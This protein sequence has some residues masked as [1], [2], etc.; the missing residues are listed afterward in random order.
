MGCLTSFMISAGSNISRLRYQGVSTCGRTSGGSASHP[1][2]AARGLED[3]LLKLDFGGPIGL[4][5]LGEVE[6]VLLLFENRFLPARAGAG[7]QN[8]CGNPLF[9]RRQHRN[10]RTFGVTDHEHALVVDVL[11]LGDP[12][13]HRDGVFGVVAKRHGFDAAAALP[14]AALVESQHDVAEVGELA[15]ELREQRDARH[16]DIAVNRP[17]PE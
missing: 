4:R 13:H 12:F 11:P 5:D 15:R 14:D 3:L 6:Q 1:C 10:R 7:H 16:G 2:S 17:D 9:A 8:Q